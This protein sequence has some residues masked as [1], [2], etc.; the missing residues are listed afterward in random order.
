MGILREIQMVIQRDF[1]MGIVMDFDWK[2]DF[3]TEKLKNLDSR[4]A[5]QNLKG[6]N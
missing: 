4:K 6:I 2:T 3:G 5:K 1:Q